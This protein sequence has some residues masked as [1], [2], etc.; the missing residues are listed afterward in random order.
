[1]R[2]MSAEVSEHQGGILLPDIDSVKAALV[3]FSRGLTKDSD[4]T[5][6]TLAQHGGGMA[7]MMLSMV[8]SSPDSFVGKLCQ[9]M[10]R[11]LSSSDRFYRDYDYDG[12]GNFMKTSIEVQRL[13]GGEF[14]LTINAAYVGNQGEEG[15]AEYLDAVRGLWWTKVTLTVDATAG[16]RFAIDFQPISD[17]L[18]DTMLDTYSATETAKI[19]A[20]GY[21]EEGGSMIMN[22]GIVTLMGDQLR[23]SHIAD[24]ID[25]Q[26]TVTMGIETLTV[27]RYY[28]EPFKSNGSV[29]TGS[30]ETR[31]GDY[32][33]QQI[34]IN[35][36]TNPSKDWR[37]RLPVL[38]LEVQARMREMATDLKSRFDS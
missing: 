5:Q 21:D 34:F 12:A 19:I 17:K 23:G 26:I 8:Q 7:V 4:A 30:A 18:A 36:A 9:Q 1:M 13:E 20:D 16:D 15:V 14:L 37:K 29:V 24:S 38:S 32:P 10:E 22:P 11:T 3:A 33:G 27:G 25:S 6:R 31:Y 35:I 2:I 28:D